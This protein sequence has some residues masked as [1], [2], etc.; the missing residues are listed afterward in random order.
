MW[1]SKLREAVPRGEPTAQLGAVS[2]TGE[3]LGVYL[4]GERRNVALISPGGY[5]W[6]PQGQETVLALACGEEESPCLLGREQHLEGFALEAGE[7]WIS[8][9]GQNGLHL[10]RDGKLNLIGELLLNGTSFPPP[11]PATDGG[12]GT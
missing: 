2:L 7:V 5:H 4:A 3:V 12:A 1:I 9:D 8:A 11:E 6:Q 10:R